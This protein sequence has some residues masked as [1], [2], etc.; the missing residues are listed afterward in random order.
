MA[1]T[2]ILRDHTDCGRYGSPVGTWFD[3]DKAH[4]VGRNDEETLL[5]T[6]KENWILRRG[7]D[8]VSHFQLSCSEA[9]QWCVQNAVDSPPPGLEEEL[10]KLER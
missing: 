2:P 6:R 10:A 9:A 3:A 7:H 1:R 4:V 5:W 8:P